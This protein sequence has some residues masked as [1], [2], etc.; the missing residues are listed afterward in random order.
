MNTIEAIKESWGWTG[1]K[2][3]KIIKENDFGNL[4]ILDK[5]DNYWRLCP[6]DL[7]CEIIANN[8][9]EFE[10]LLHDEE[11][12]IDWNMEIMVNEAKEKYGSLHEGIKFHLA[13]P[14]ILGGEYNITNIKTAPLLEQI[15]FSGN[16]GKQIKELPDGTEVKIKVI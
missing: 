2:P 10:V 15:K 12:I 13:M 14:G 8:A 16:L 5:Q 11:F 1:I 9:K 4:I 6:E 3:I 7:Y